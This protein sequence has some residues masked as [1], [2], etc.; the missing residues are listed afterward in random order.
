MFTMRSMSWGLCVALLATA[1][2]HAQEQPRRPA[3]AQEPLGGPLVSKA[4]EEKLKLTADQKEKV[5]KIEKDFTDKAKDEAKLR[6]LVE[7]ARQDKDRAAYKE[8][9]EKINE[10]KKVRAEYLS[11]VTALLTAEQKKALE[12]GAGAE[13][14]PG[15]AAPGQTAG[16][17]LPGALQERLGLTAEQKEKLS[18]IQKEFE[19]KALQVLTDEQ[20]Q[21]YEQF[22]KGRTRPPQQ[23]QRR[24]G[25]T[26]QQDT[27]TP[28]AIGRLR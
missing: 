23:S 11:K 7:K 21:K 8:A 25:A 18:A 1:G 26:R 12:P 2:A 24:T 10:A 6:E 9:Q 22:K 13:R 17:L 28:P 20:R 3:A 16:T 27:A 19:A 4:V 5:A 15:A 14:R